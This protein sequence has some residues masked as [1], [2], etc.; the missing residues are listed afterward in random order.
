MVTLRLLKPPP[1]GVVIGAL[2]NTLVRRS[3]SQELGSMP[4]VLPR[5]I[6]L[7]ADLDGLDF[8]RAP[9]RLQDVERGG[10]DFG[11]DAVAVGDGDRSFGGHR[12]NNQDIGM[13]HKAQQ[14]FAVF[15]YIAGM[16]FRRIA[17]FGP[18]TPW[19]SHSG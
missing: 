2:R 7:L 10:H 17:G 9:G 19:E 16:K 1:C 5:K 14:D 11:A 13:H 15:F 12:A 18:F 3:E 8:E 4:A 6:D